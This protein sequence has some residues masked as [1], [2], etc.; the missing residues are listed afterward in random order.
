[1]RRSVFCLIRDEAA[2]L[3]LIS[4]S[5]SHQA[6]YNIAHQCGLIEERQII[7]MMNGRFLS[8]LITVASGAG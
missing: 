8:R 7:L 1:M 5:D 6:E 2:K 3:Y 4:I